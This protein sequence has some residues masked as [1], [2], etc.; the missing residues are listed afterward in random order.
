MHTRATRGALETIQAH[1]LYHLAYRDVSCGRKMKGAARENKGDDVAPS[2][3][4]EH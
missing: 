1:L 4:G 2:L 3:Y